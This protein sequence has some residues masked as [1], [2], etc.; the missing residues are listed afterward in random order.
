ML[1][2][3]NINILSKKTFKIA[4]ISIICIIAAI[5][6]Y[7]YYQIPEEDIVEII[8][9]SISETEGISYSTQDIRIRKQLDL[10]Y[11]K[12]VV[13]SFPSANKS[14]IVGVADF[15]K[16][17]LTN[18]YAVN[19][20]IYEKDF[21][22]NFVMKG[23][24]NQY[25]IITGKNYNRNIDTI[26]VTWDDGNM[27]LEDI[28]RQDYFIFSIDVSFLRNWCLLDK[29]GKQLPEGYDDIYIEEE[30]KD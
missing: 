1:N 3:L 28:S 20:I 23:L 14:E 22:Y 18:K 29:E 13:Y 11:S 19:S 27:N 5:L 9:K 16:G 30:M 26:E 10:E 15:Y 4:A 21:V 24:K 17:L 6:H 2:S 7:F 8:A 12:V 25:L